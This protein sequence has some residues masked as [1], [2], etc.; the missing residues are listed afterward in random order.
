MPIEHSPEADTFFLHAGNTTYAMKV[1]AQGYLT[2]LYWGPRV[3]IQDLDFVLQFRDRAFSPNPDGLGR[4]FSLDTI[5]LEYPV[6]GN[7]DFRAPALEVFQ[8]EDGSRIVNLRFKDHK[9][10]AGKPSLP[11]LPATWV[12]MESEAETLIIGLED[13]K[14]NLRVELS[15]TA[16]ADHPAI[17]R[18]T[19]IV[20]RG[21]SPLTL[22]RVLSC[23]IDFSS[24]QT[25]G[26]FLHLS[27]AHLR[28]REIY[29]APLRPGIQ[30]IESRRGSSSHQ[31]NPFFALTGPD[32]NED[33]GAVY[34]F[35]LVYSG[36]FLAWP[37]AM[38]IMGAG[39][40][41]GSIPLTFPGSLSRELSF[42]PPK[43][44]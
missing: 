20:H 29:C 28:E 3:A 2:H 22:R 26:R 5:P 21:T 37:S 35:N 19:R 24:S 36:N 41:L 4:E 7:T 8:S 25:E 34:G 33:H 38:P 39:R 12:E 6:H 11:G 16:F 43:R 40:S 27:G 9:I 32:T 1:L 10:V 15:Y 13:S 23:S 31:H 42:K 30:S 14:L 18:S 44:C 17:A